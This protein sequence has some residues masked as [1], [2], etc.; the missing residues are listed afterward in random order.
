MSR[1]G[2]SPLAYSHICWLS[3]TL[4]AAPTNETCSED[5]D[6]RLVNGRTALEGRVEI[7]YDGRWGTV[8]DNSW[9]AIDGRVACRQ[10]GYSPFGKE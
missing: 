5:G 8:C 7:C 2:T 9:S 3:Y 6:I 4:L 10:L 1:F